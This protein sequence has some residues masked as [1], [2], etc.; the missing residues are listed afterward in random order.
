MPERN[1]DKIDLAAA[2]Q[3]VAAAK[4]STAEM[5]V[6]VTSV[7]ESAQ[8]IRSIVEA[9]GYVRRFRELIRGA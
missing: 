6:V 2:Q 7:H 1:E 9:N 5:D 8:N 3:A 4:Q